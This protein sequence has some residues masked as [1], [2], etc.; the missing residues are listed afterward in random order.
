MHV[1]TLIHLYKVVFLKI[2]RISTYLDSGGAE[3]SMRLY[4]KELS[5]R[6]E[7]YLIYFYGND[8]FREE[9]EKEG[10]ITYQLPFSITG[11]VRSLVLYKF[12]K[13]DVVH[14]SLYKAEFFGFLLKIFY[15]CRLVTNRDVDIWD[16]SKYRAFNRIID[17]IFHKYL[18][19]LFVDKIIAITH[20]IRNYMLYDFGFRTSKIDVVYY[21]LPIKNYTKKKKRLNNKLVVGFVGRLV[22]QKGIDTFVKTLLNLKI[23][24]KI[25]VVVCGDGYYRDFLKLVQ[26]YMPKN[27]ELRLEGHVKNINSYY[28]KMHVLFL[29]TK[30]EGF[31][32]VFIESLL[33]NIIVLTSNIKPLDEVLDKHALF[34]KSENHECFAEKIEEIY[35]NYDNIYNNLFKDIENHLDKFD[36]KKN[37]KYLENIYLSLTYG[38]S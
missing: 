2:M 8:K 12:I 5:K 16:F 15:R 17:K 14:T 34:C 28:E 20:H 27:V 10:I 1:S 33:H 9:M 22:Y 6:N 29:P 25:E 11:M 31:G 36:I 23:K 13:P 37:A 7:V 30:Y 32:L 4:L 21:G 26:K 18:Y 24:K 3:T 19:Y 35:K 38:K